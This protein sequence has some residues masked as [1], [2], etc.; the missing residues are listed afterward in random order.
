V[1]C[2][3][4]EAVLFEHPQ[5]SDVAVIG[6]LEPSMGERVCAVVVPRAGT[7]LELTEVRAFVAA[8]LAAF[9]CPEA[10]YTADELPRTATGKTAK[11][12][13]RARVSSDPDGV[14]Q[15]W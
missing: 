15:A 2:A 5:I 3:E 8:R 11:S 10:L 14:T 4:V 7:T 12:E 1:Y 9:K 13:L 6:L